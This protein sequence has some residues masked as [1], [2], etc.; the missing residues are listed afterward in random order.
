MTKKAERECSVCGLFYPADK[1]ELREN[2][3]EMIAAAKSPKIGGTIRGVIGPHAGYVYSGP[4]A[5][6]AYAL[7][8]GATYSTVVVVSPSHRE[9]F[10][11][12]SVFPGDSYST[13]LGVVPVDKD[14]REKLL[15]QTPL[16]NLSYSGHGEEHAV[17]VHL[18]FLQYVLGE[19]K[20]LPLV[21]GDQKREC[22]F[23]LGEALGEVLKGKNALLVAS[24]DLSHYYPSSVANKLD[25]IVV[26]HVNKFD[27][28][29]LMH[30][31]E[32]QQAEACGGG[33]TVAVM[34]ALER[35]GVREMTVLHHCNSGDVTGDSHQVVGYLSAAAYA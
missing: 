16:V 2:I 5:A 1:E 27:Y 35:L 4:T 13:P 7:L 25:A 23:G 12:V 26:N 11:G 28:E 21:V 30:D 3:R 18:P 34:L 8:Q 24:T 14:L 32:S 19:F 10:D 33:P 31:L 6:H 9:Y 15:Q 29:G 22:C 20:F 17:E